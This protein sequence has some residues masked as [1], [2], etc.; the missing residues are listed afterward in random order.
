MTLQQFL[1]SR[2]VE[3]WQSWILAL[4]GKGYWRKSACPQANQALSNKWFDEIGLYNLTL[5]YE[6]LNN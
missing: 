2:G 5:N 4:S 3:T 6:K 1:K